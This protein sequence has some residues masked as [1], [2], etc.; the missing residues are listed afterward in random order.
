MSGYWNGPFQCIVE[1]L[2][3]G[4]EHGVVHMLSL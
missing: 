3:G 1:G 2:V 4:A